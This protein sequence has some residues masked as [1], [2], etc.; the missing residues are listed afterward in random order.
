MRFCAG[1][2][3]CDCEIAFNCSGVR[4]AMAGSKAYN[5]QSVKGLHWGRVRHLLH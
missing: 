5:G 2:E 4:R 3:G 1:W